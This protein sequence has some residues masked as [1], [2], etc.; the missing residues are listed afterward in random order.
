MKKSKR[1]ICSVWKRA[2][3]LLAL[4]EKE[5]KSDLL[6]MKKS[7]RA[8][9]SI[10]KRAKERKSDSLIFVKKR[11]IRTKSQRAKVRTYTILYIDAL[12]C[13][14]I[15]ISNYCV[16][17][18]ETSMSLF[19]VTINSYCHDS[20]IIPTLV[21]ATASCYFLPPERCSLVK[22]SYFMRN[23]F[24]QYNFTHFSKQ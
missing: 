12:Y 18:V 5:R 24:S 20:T 21:T 17:M 2:K 16:Y 4:Y 1:A 22:V 19:K 11:V 15:H 8:I 13:F 7:E 9:R 6:Y 10:W 3:E 14:Y 23:T